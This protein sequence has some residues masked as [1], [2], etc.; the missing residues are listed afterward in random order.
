VSIRCMVGA[1]GI[2][3]NNVRNLKDLREM[4]R[5]TKSL[6]RNNEA[7]KGILIAPSKLPRFSRSLRFKRSAISTQGSR[8]GVG[9]GPNFAAR[10]ASRR[11][12]KR[13]RFLSMCRIPFHYGTGACG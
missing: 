10:M 2:E 8:P 9:F 4:R 13:T 6:K 3:N 5:N 11:L 1:V 7:C 12:S